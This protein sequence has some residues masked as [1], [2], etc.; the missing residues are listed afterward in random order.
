VKLRLLAGTI[1]DYT[2][3]D[4]WKNFTLDVSERK[5][6]DH[7]LESFVMPDFLAD[8]ADGVELA[9]MREEM[10]DQIRFHHVLEHIPIDRAP[11]AVR[12][13]Y[14]L[15]KPG[16]ELDI[17]VPD[18]DVIVRAYIAGDLALEG[19]AHT[20]Y[21]CHRSVWTERTIRGVL[22]ASGFRTPHSKS[23]SEYAVRFLARRP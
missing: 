13:L 22:S 16:G 1:N 23:V 18:V 17:E 20:I 3:E 10:F 9:D 15:L 11:A 21:D 2:A 12:T 4:G 6:W 8:V 14:R 19:L 7:D 5:V